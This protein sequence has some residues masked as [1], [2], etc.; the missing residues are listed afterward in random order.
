MIKNEYERTL[1]IVFDHS[2]VRE[3]SLVPAAIL[4]SLITFQ[5]LVP[6]SQDV[7]GKL[8]SMAPK[9]V[10]NSTASE[11][12]EYEVNLWKLGEALFDGPD[13]GDEDDTLT[14]DLIRKD[15]FSRWLKAQ[16]KPAA[17]ADLKNSSSAGD[18]I[19]HLLIS[20][21]VK[22][23]VT[24]ALCDR[25]LHL[26]TILSQ[27]SD[28]GGCNMPYSGGG[29]LDD[30]ARDDIYTQLTAWLK[31]NNRGQLK[32][33]EQWPVTPDFIRLYRLLCSDLEPIHAERKFDWKRTLGM[34]LWSW[35]T[36][37]M[38]LSQVV[39]AF[40]Y[41]FQKAKNVSP[42]RPWYVKNDLERDGT[43]LMFSMIRAHVHPTA[44]LQSWNNIR[45][46]YPPCQVARELKIGS[47]P[48]SRIAWMLQAVLASQQKNDSSMQV[49][50]N[51]DSFLIVDCDSPLVRRHVLEENTAS[52]LAV[53]FAIELESAGLW[54]W[55]VFVLMFIA[56]AA[57]REALIKGVLERAVAAI[58]R[59]ELI[60]SMKLGA[61]ME[62][63][64]NP[65]E[66]VYSTSDEKFLL[67][68][69]AISESWLD[70]VK[71]AQCR[72]VDDHIGEAAYLLRSGHHVEAHSLLLERFIV[73]SFLRRRVSVVKDLVS[74]MSPSKISEWRLGAGLFADFYKFIDEQD[75][76]LKNSLRND[77][78]VRLH[79][80]EQSRQKGDAIFTR[81]VIHTPE[82]RLAMSEMISMLLSDE[83][84]PQLHMRCSYQVLSILEEQFLMGL[85]LSV[86][87]RTVV[88]DHFSTAF[89]V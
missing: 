1:Q 81:K 33:S 21:Q 73:S 75:I 61:V 37:D 67:E 26:A 36:C 54:K 23:A 12:M 45:S 51:N 52:T 19:F 34:Y 27:I 83:V 70:E 79:G 62:K 17:D 4:S 80:L 29:G 7:V 42:P 22:E 64:V 41:S 84:K 20:R 2:T 53:S 68:K 60:A 88:A 40:E 25:K 77:L 24:V 66:C 50:S 65:Q 44:T 48:S 49:D 46:Y 38:P 9:S 57:T 69:L 72:L 78:L 30:N 47:V 32:S 8:K 71:V 76:K 3:E 63:S 85:P 31:P 39:S 58:D 82:F 18:Q 5:S 13:L 86:S 15:K 10:Y 35:S 56:S 6:K 43:D 87:Q 89:F 74:A 14:V 55:S 11:M 59:N 28:S 16:V